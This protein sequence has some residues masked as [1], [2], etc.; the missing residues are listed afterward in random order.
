MRSSNSARVYKSN[1]T[2]VKPCSVHN[3]VF[4][5]VVHQLDTIIVMMY[6]GADNS[7]IDCIQSRPTECGISCIA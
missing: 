4:K 1:F 5:I 2:T 6:L 3:A 7:S